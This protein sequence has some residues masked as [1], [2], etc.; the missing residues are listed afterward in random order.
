[1]GVEVGG[2]ATKLGDSYER[3][4]AVRQV[5]Y[6]IEGRLASVL[7]E[8][9]G[10]DEN[11]ID[12]WVRKTDG[13]RVG[14]QLKR[15]NRDKE[16]WTVADLREE[17]VLQSAL[18]QL[19]RNDFSCYV[20]VSSCPVRHLRDFTEQSLRADN[21]ATSFHQDIVSSS[22]ERTRAFDA[23][24]RTW[25]LNSN[26]PNDLERAFGLL[27]RMDFHV[28][29]RTKSTR[30][31]VEFA[32]GLLVDGDPATVV[33]TLGDYL[34]SKLGNEL[35]ADE[36]RSALS[37]RGFQFRRLAGHP[38][39]AAVI[40]GLQDRFDRGISHALIANAPIARE[41]A[42]KILA[43]IIGAEPPRLVFLHGPAGAGKSVVAYQLFRSLI[44]ARIPCLPLQLHVRRPG[45]TPD[46]YGR[47]SLG[48]P[49]S[50]SPSLR[51]LAGD[52]RAVLILDQLDALRLT[53]VHSHEAWESCISII[54]EALADPDMTVIVVCRSFDLE[55]DPKIGLWRR[56]QLA[57]SGLSQIDVAVGQ[58]PE[59]AAAELV[60]RYGVTFATLPARQQRLLRHPGVLA[61][62]WT[63]AFTGRVSSTFE[64]STHLMRDYLALRRAE[65]ARDHSVSQSEVADLLAHM[66]TYLDTNGR[67]DAPEA[68]FPDHG[69]TVDALCSVGL[70][71]RDGAVLCFAHQSYFD[72]LVAER[73]LS[74][75]ALS[76]KNPLTWLKSNQS[77]FRRDQL[78]QLLTLL[79]DSDGD[80]H[81]VLL[82]NALQDT[83]VRFHL[84]ELV[85]GLLSQADPP[86]DHELNVV[87]ELAGQPG[88]WEHIQKSVVWAK[89]AWFEALEH[90]RHLHTWL[91]TWTNEHSIQLLLSFLRSV[92]GTCGGRID[93]LLSQYWDFGEPWATR[94]TAVFSIDPSD[95]SDGMAEFRLKK[96]RRGE[97]SLPVGMNIKTIAEH[98]PRRVVPLIEAAVQSWINRVRDYMRGRR[99]EAPKWPLRD[100]RLE[101]KTL[102]AIQS[103]CKLAWET[104]SRAARSLISLRRRASRVRSL[105]ELHTRDWGLSYEI[106]TALEFVETL[107]TAAVQG[108][109]ANAPAEMTELLQNYS[110]SRL[111][112]LERAIAIGMVG[113]ADS[114]ADAALRWL[115]ARPA[116]FCLGNGQDELRWRPATDLLSRYAHICSPPVFEELESCVLAYHDRDERG[117]FHAQREHAREGIYD[118]G[119]DWGRAQNHLLHALPTERLSKRASHRSLTWL[120]KFG[121]P[122]QVRPLNCLG[123]GGWVT[124]PIRPDR[125][126]F[127][128]DRQWLRIISRDWSAAKPTRYKQ[129]GPN[130]VGEA[131]LRQFVDAFGEAATKSPARFARLA[132][133]IPPTAHSEYFASLLRALSR[134]SSETTDNDEAATIE[135]LEAVIKHVGDCRDNE[136][137]QS[138]CWLI[139][140][141]PDAGWSDDTVNRVIGFVDHPHPEPG[142]FT[143]TSK[144]EP[145]FVST[146][147]NCV[148]GSV[149]AAV[150]TLFWARSDAFDQLLI[151]VRRLLTDPHPSV[152]IAAL[153]ACVPIWNHD[154]LLACDLALEACD[155]TEDA[156]LQ[157][158]GLQRL[159]AYARITQVDKLTPLLKRMVFS[160]IDDVAELGAAWVTACWLDGV[161]LDEMVKGCRRGSKAQRLG[162]VDVAVQYL[163]DARAPEMA[164][165]LVEE[166]F[167]D[168]DADVRRRAAR[169]FH[170]DGV[171]ETNAVL[172]LADT[173][174]RSPSFVDSPDSL[175]HSLIE[176]TGNITQFSSVVFEAA[177]IVAGPLADSTRHLSRRAAFAGDEVSTLLLRLYETAYSARSRTLQD[178]CLDR[179][180]R[181]LENGVGLPRSHLKRL[182]D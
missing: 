22:K 87:A 133:R 140:S 19:D 141:R 112:G 152:R 65:A 41:E 164:T 104:F 110:G 36:L 45:G 115:F 107:V 77:L 178:G 165:T 117:S 73:V 145:D 126:Q 7:W 161:D 114:L 82:R 2:R 108:M 121:D 40:E 44:G 52:R 116:R 95:D 111:R 48:L 57:D 1:M 75:A 60:G 25:D 101:T 14:H 78:R 171:W 139:S 157:S 113:G 91:K 163:S 5:L 31:E 128:S 70:L 180:D 81:E 166:A 46:H 148:R 62:W 35:H 92:A 80:L 147:I 173:F 42:T 49:A 131:S 3:L 33:A 132:L 99:D 125:L 136:Y 64:N 16:Y 109:S 135:E 123:V 85:L 83:G 177:D 72:Y 30:N 47:T 39:L 155:Q 84:K 12:I 86:M 90:R 55:N 102:G 93:A 143:A 167:E 26:S 21:N 79:R 37:E 182:D 118:S 51:A 15:Q 23:L 138:A 150:S 10:D 68:L 168:S 34:D 27:Q 17:N 4:W 8:P 96:I 169:V 63:L 74:E 179:W 149:A 137:V 122:K 50:P 176:Y 11:G 59:A 9:I 153:R 6:V 66:V 88:W 156:V 89:P 28:L 144:G 151:S 174:V 53:S 54:D 38:S 94:L 124:S 170:T 103:D 159:L 13:T 76:A 146:A 67:L 172:P 100:E 24:M 154:H 69:R 32:A 175:L 130:V 160:P 71:R 61:L 56:G 97:W 127:V 158:P 142:V 105:D 120:A 20:F 98:T 134:D 58:L 129:H 18:A 43:K 119:N 181:L 29:E 106:S 162:V